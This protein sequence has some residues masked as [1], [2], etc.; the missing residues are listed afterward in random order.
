MNSTRLFGFRQQVDLKKVKIDPLERLLMRSSRAGGARSDSFFCQR[1]PDLE[2][3]TFG[4]VT[5]DTDLAM[6]RF[7]NP[8][9]DSEAQP[10]A[11]RFPGPRRI[12][13]VEPIEDMRDMLRR[14]TDSRVTN[15][16][17]CESIF[18]IE[19]H[20]YFPAAR[21]IF[22]RVIQQDQEEPFKG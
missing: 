3:G 19:P 15:F 10:G 18:R 21:R 4:I 20:V 8:V 12:R 6:V 9:S 13:S 16:G 11:S 5:G 22:H 7:R 14:D 17:H 1:N 2:R